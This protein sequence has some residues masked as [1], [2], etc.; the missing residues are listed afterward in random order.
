M[1]KR[2]S[3]TARYGSLETG[4]YLID[5]G[6][7]DRMREV[8][9]RI[10]DGEFVGRLEKLEAKDVTSINR[11]VKCLTDPALEKAAKKFSK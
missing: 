5:Q 9:A 1:F 7:K 2:I 3:L 10:R 6:V 8:F 11:A 4:P